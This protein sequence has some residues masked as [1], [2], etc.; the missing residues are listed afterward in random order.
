M[1]MREDFC[2]F[3]LTH[4]RP[5]RVHTYTTLMR[6]GYT[7]KVF[8][9]ID[10]EDKTADEYRKRYG[11]KVLQFCKAQYAAK[12]DEGDNTGKRI[13]TIY[14][15]AAL[16]DLALLA[17]CR[18]FI[19]L[20]DDYNSGFYIRFNSRLQYINPHQIH[21]SIDGVLSALVDFLESSGAITVCLSQGGDHIGGGAGTSPRLKRKAMNSFVCST[22]RPWVMLGRMNEDVTTYVVGGRKGVLFFTIQQAQVNQLATQSNAGGMADLYLDT[23]TYVKTFYSVMYAPSCVSVGTL[24]DPRSPHY[25]IHHKINWHNCAPKI[26]REEYKK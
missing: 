26:L 19:Q 15:R 18:Y 12:L 1:A 3:I 16:F 14:A 6:A 2:A 21:A 4:G 23:G 11:D 24:G 20:D 10:D 22:D 7:G 25:R 17:G 13:S 8:I 9:I 5:D